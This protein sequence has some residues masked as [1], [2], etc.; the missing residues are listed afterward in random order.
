MSAISTELRLDNAL[1]EASLC[2][3]KG[4]MCQPYCQP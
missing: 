2:V 4:A 1:R 3:Y